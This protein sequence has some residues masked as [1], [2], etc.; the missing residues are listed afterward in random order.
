M[1]RIAHFESTKVAR[2]YKC[3]WVG[4]TALLLYLLVDQKELRSSWF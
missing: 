3:K 1:E 2:T 4:L